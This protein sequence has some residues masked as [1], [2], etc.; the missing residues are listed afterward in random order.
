MNPVCRYTS[1][2]P[3]QHQ[4]HI[5]ASTTASEVQSTASVAVAEKKWPKKGGRKNKTRITKSKHSSNETLK[6]STQ[7]KGSFG[8]PTVV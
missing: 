6:F 4:I 7:W 2:P 1:E 3:Q 8:D 5:K